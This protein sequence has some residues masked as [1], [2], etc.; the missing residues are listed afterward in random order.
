MA[1]RIRWTPR[2]TGRFAVAAGLALLLGAPLAWAAALPPR[3]VGEPPGVSRSDVTDRSADQARTS[4][5]APAALSTAPPAAVPSP[6]AA[7]PSPPSPWTTTAPAGAIDPLR[8]PIEV[9][10]PV[11]GVAAPVEPVGLGAGGE[12]GIPDSPTTVGWF[13]GAALPGDAGT[14][15]LASHVD[16][17]HEGLGVF[18]GLIRI[19]PGD[20]VELVAADGTSAAWTVVARQ[21]VPKDE[22]PSGRLFAL[23]GDPVLALVTCGGRFDAATRSY[24]DNV[25]VWAVPAS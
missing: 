17:R 22:L 6:P 7:V 2:V 13:R 1:P 20:T 16:S 12:V 9:R 23:G 11:L 10:I 8:W 3:E 18:A 15:V 5:P 21:Q 4:A 19:A 25:I 14:A 24:A